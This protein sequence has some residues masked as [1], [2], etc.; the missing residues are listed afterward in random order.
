MSIEKESTGLPEVDATRRTTK[1][2]LGVII[3][4][5]LFLAAMFLVLFAFARR[6]D[7]EANHPSPAPQQGTASGTATEPAA[8]GGKR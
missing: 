4:A 6:S 5:A 7:R 2:N 1:V 8:R 3:G